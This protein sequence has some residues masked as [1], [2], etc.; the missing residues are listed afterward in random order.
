MIK[1]GK[2]DEELSNF[3]SSR[4]EPGR[5]IAP[6]TLWRWKNYGF[7][8][9]LQKS[10]KRERKKTDEMKAFETEVGMLLLEAS[11]HQTI[12]CSQVKWFCHEIRERNR[13]YT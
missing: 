9:I 12:D 8:R 5:P 3:W 1:E 4:T 13:N 2:S 10:T 6:S 7:Q 11:R